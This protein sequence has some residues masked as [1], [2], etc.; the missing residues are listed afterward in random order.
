MEEA[1]DIHYDVRHTKE[2]FAWAERLVGGKLVGARQQGRWRPQHFLDIQMPS[3]EVKT[4]LLRGFR[5]P[6]GELTEDASRDLLRKEAAICKTMGESGC[7]TAK[8]YGYEPNGGWFL[9]E[10]LRGSPDFGNISDQRVRDKVFGEYIDAIV[11]LHKL[12][13]KTLDLPDGLPISKNYE[14]SIS[15]MLNV[16]R[17]P[18]DKLG[19]EGPQPT[20]KLGFWFVENHRPKPVEFFSLCTGDI[21][22]GQFMYEGDKFTGLIDLEMAYVGD[23]MED[24]GATRL[25]DLCYP[26]PGLAGHLRHWAEAM[27]R[28]L[29]RESVGYWTVLHMLQGPLMIYPIW[30]RP[31]D[32]VMSHGESCFNHSFL[33]HYFRGMHEAL[34]EYYNIELEP[35]EKPAPRRDIYSVYTDWLTEQ[36]KTYYPTTTSDDVREFDYACSAALA[37]TV[38]LTR[39]IAPQLTSAN[40]QDFEALLGK[41]VASEEEGLAAI[42]ERIEED[43]ERDLEK[44]IIT[45]HRY[46]SRREFIIEPLQKATGVASGWPLQR[47]L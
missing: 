32:F 27:N 16:Y 33:P 43:P 28:E 25:R 9:M 38:A 4:L 34:A 39:S 35:P 10:T 37:E 21:G 47:I 20:V 5:A 24:I 36:F 11:H 12:D 29:D 2:A 13:W 30:S 45:L 46:E 3:G 44:T 1:L 6:V 17:A 14:H 7:A 8:F 23:P 15:M 31:K 26:V 42:E 22:S 19:D 18:Y 40:I 41:P